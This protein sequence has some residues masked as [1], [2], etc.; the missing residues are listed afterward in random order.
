MARSKSAPA[1]VC[2]SEPPADEDTSLLQF[3]RK[4]SV[5]WQCFLEEYEMWSD[6]DPTDGGKI[7]AA[8]QAEATSVIVGQM[9]M[10]EVSFVAMLQRNRYSEKNRPVQVM[11]IFTLAPSY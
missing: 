1:G 7:E 11:G 3:E 10:Y 6:Y 5:R 2:R 9:E 8:W 4:F